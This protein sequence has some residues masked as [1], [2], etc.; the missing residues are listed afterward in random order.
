MKKC[1]VIGGGAAGMMIAAVLAELGAG[2]GG[3]EVVLL[4]KNQELGKKV[5]ISGGGRCSVTT[6]NEDLKEVLKA[7]PR[8]GRFFRTALYGFAPVMVREWFEERGVK[9]KVEKDMR[10]F[11]VSDDGDDVVAVFERIFREKGVKVQFGQEVRGIEKVGEEFVVRT[12]D[13]EWKADKVFLA[14]G[15]QAYRHTGSAGDGYKLAEDLGHSITALGPSLNSF[16]VEED[17][18]KSLS[19]VSSQDVR[20]RMA[21]EEFQ[22]PMIFTHKGISGPA[23]FALSSL[24]AFEKINRSTPLKLQLDFC[25][26]RDYENLRTELIKMSQK[27]TLGR[28]MARFITKSFV[29][30]Y[31]EV[32]NLNLEKR[33]AEVGK[34]DLNKVVDALKNTQITVIGRL[35]GDEFVTAG[36]V[37]LS[38]VDNKTMESKLCPNLYF[39]GEILNIDGF[40]GG[41]NLQVAWATGKLAGQSGASLA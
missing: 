30:K 12:G 24:C 34:K 3:C 41:Y 35:P 1:I 27:E 36:G 23:I 25:P 16:L 6:G 33:G 26:G 2:T 31:C 4:E 40:T 17:W 13:K 18:V 28:A 29:A 7:Y 21:G 8:G 32:E 20:M 9:L 5:K 38:E 15:G 22:G 37:E 19:G 11:P 10:V 14:L 39:A